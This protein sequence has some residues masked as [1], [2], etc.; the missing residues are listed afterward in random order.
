MEEQKQ[1]ELDQLNDYIKALELKI[2]QL[3]Q[4]NNNLQA[5]KIALFDSYVDS[6]Q[7]VFRV[8]D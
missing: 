1:S 8:G 4:D 2:D 3:A 7:K 6:Q 5:E